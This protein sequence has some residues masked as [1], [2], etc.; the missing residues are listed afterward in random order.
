MGVVVEQALCDSSTGILPVARTGLES[1]RWGGAVAA[2]A[3]TA[4]AAVTVAAA[5]AATATAGPQC[6]EGMRICRWDDWLALAFTASLAA[7]CGGE[8][9]RWERQTQV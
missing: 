3:A 1:S 2:A 7:V 4:A 5:A 6:D 8:R 9:E